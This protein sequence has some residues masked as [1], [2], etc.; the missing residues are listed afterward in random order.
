RFQKLVQ[1][2]KLA[3]GALGAVGVALMIGLAVSAWLLVNERA[4]RRL[5]VVAQ[6]KGRKEA[7]KSQQVAAVLK[8][9]LEAVGPSKARGRD[10]TMLQEI[11]DQTAKTVG[12]DLTNQPEVAVELYLTL[13]DTYHDLGAYKRMEEV[14]RQS[15]QLARLR[16]GQE[17]AGT[18]LSLT[19]L[20]D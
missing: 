7:A 12:R 14:A 6:E 2:N 10:T 11:L 15:L 9:M 4:A 16:Q 3:F 8:N 13:A 1:R 20:G 18:A 17:N 19:A 5:A